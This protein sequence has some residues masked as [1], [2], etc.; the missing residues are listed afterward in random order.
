M[1]PTLKAG[2]DVL[3]WCW[4]YN[5]KKGD[6]A[7]FKNNGKDMIK[8]IQNA[9]GCKYFVIGDNKKESI[10]SRSFGWISKDQIIGKVIWF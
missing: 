9:F 3:V 1:C 8:R 5:P 6:L 2:Q 10:D 7:V 4:F